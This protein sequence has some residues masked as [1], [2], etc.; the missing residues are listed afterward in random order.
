MLPQTTGAPIIR[1]NGRY[2]SQ[3]SL[4]LLATL[5]V[6]LAAA[7]TTGLQYHAG[8]R[9]AGDAV[10]DTVGNGLRGSMLESITRAADEPGFLSVLLAGLVH[11][12]PPLLV[13]GITAGVWERIFSVARGK[14][15]DRGFLVIAVLFTL[16]C[17]PAI[18]LVQ[19]IFGLSFG[20]VF[21]YAV[22]GGAGKAFLNPALLGAVVVQVSFPAALSGHPV[23]SELAGHGGT[24]L[25]AA[26]Q[27]QGEAALAW[28]GIDWW[29]AFQGL[30]QG[31]MGETAIAAIILGGSLLVAAGLA[32]TRIIVGVVIGV[33]AGAWLC[34]LYGGAAPDAG[35]LAM[36]WYWHLVLGGLPFGVVFL[37]TDPAASAATNPGRWAQGVLIGLLIVLLRVA[38]PAHP[39]GVY[40]VLL[41]VSMLAPLVDHLVIAAN[42]RRRRSRNV[43]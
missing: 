7:Y 39:D 41:F 17:H 31:M 22:F 28:S 23:W 20:M 38:L 32:S 33:I 2:R 4:R 12:L 35:L 3:I 1:R 42:I 25:F 11:L 14:P 9:L 37:A 34:N 15:F 18:P 29:R 30:A 26:Y 6:L 13:F 36:P 21:G 40:A 27:Q 10:G 16:L 8:V 5:P 19:G 24:T 43:C